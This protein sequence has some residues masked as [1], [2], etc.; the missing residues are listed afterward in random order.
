MTCTWPLYK[1]HS[2]H[3]SVGCKSAH[4][5][6]SDREVNRRLI[7]NLS[8]WNSKLMGKWYGNCS[9]A[10]PNSCDYRKNHSTIWN[11]IA[12]IDRLS[13]NKIIIRI[14][15]P[16]ARWHELCRH[17]IFCICV[18]VKRVN[19]FILRALL[20]SLFRIYN[21]RLITLISHNSQ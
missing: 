20:S 17:C 14:E 9:S 5:T 13:R 8:G 11:G 1:A 16:P 3:G 7:S 19:I 21:C 15:S 18:R 10:P 12:A 2:I 6:R 4:L